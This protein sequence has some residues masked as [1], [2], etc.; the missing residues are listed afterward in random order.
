MKVG[1]MAV[2]MAISTL[3]AGRASAQTSSDQAA[4]EALFKQ[5]RDLMSAGQFGDACPKFAESQHLDPAPGTLLNLATCYERNG[6]IA[7][8]WVTYK[9]AASV[10]RKADQN[11]RARLARDKAAELEPR[12]P[13]LTIVVPSASERGDLELRRDGEVVGR[14][15]WGVPIPVDPGLHVIDAVAPGHKGWQ[16]K[17]QITGAAAKQSIEVPVLDPLPNAP[18]LVVPLAPPPTVPANSTPPV[19]GAFSSSVPPS[20]APSG[21][22]TAAW[23]VGGVGVAG[24]VAGGA[25]GIVAAIDHNGASDDCIAAGSG[26]V[27][28]GSGYSQSRDA[29]HAAT[30]STV[31][32]AAGGALVVLAAVIYWTAPTKHAR[33]GWTVAPIVGMREGG[34]G[35]EGSW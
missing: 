28:N 32:L 11:D 19:D 10:A 17:T 24:L 12:L 31:A 27:C 9:E 23:V 30:A 29:V 26:V 13:T 15:E 6:Q 5:G 20:S 7:S 1:A 2:G 34:L 3:A 14:P 16:G 25:L 18:E 21:Q 35:V 8:A 4:A 33:S 22:R